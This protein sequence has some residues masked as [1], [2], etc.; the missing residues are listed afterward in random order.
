MA[1][2]FPSK[3]REQIELLSQSPDFESEGDRLFLAHEDSEARLLWAFWRPSGSHEKQLGD[4]SLDV[5]ITAFNHSR[6]GALKRLS[7]LNPAAHETEQLRK[8]FANR[9]RMLFR[10]MV[11]EDFSELVE[12]LRRFE[13][14]LP[15]ALDQIANGRRMNEEVTIDPCALCSFLQIAKEQMNES[16]WEALKSRIDIEHLSSAQLLELLERLPCDAPAKL[17][18][19][20]S[21]LVK[22]FS[23]DYALHPLQRLAL[24]NAL[25]N[26]GVQDGR[27]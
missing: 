20:Y 2:S 9:T 19:H 13:V 8:K 26:K 3:Y 11:D 4:D 27:V 24:Q 16:A 1:E 25:K 14:Y 21:K 12:V 17:V 23:E 10:S 5:A 18:D 6:L 22:K 7:L 15:I